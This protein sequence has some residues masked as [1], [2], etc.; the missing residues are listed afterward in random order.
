MK[1]LKLVIWAFPCDRCGGM[2]KVGLDER[3]RSASENCACFEGK[4]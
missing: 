1:K 2:N 4:Q 3:D